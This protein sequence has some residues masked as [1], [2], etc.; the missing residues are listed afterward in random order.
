[1]TVEQAKQ[2]LKD[3]GYYVENLWHIEDVKVHYDCTD[4]EAQ[5]ILHAVL[6][7]PYIVETIN[8]VITEKNWFGDDSNGDDDDDDF[9]HINLLTGGRV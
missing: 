2:V 7:S 9:V 1:M 3:N 8:E 6:H 4:E 5:Q